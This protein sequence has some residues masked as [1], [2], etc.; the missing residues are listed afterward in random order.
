MQLVQT[1]SKWTDLWG[2]K[3]YA[4]P[5]TCSDVCL[6]SYTFV[7]LASLLLVLVLLDQLPKYRWVSLGLIDLEGI[8]L[9]LLDAVS[10]QLC[11]Q[12]IC[13]VSAHN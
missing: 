13:C 10:E 12:N 6:S 8:A 9:A 3:T 4:A 1:R 11:N 5:E 7:A 2:F